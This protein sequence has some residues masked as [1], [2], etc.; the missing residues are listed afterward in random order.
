MSVD[1]KPIQLHGWHRPG[2]RGQGFAVLLCV[3]ALAGCRAKANAAGGADMELTIPSFHQGQIPVEHTCDGADRSPQMTWTAPPAGTKSMTL[4]V[5]DPDA[6]AGT[7]VH[8]VLFDM[9]A[10]RHQLAAGVPA[11]AQLADG[12]R[13]GHNDFGRIG[14][15]GPCPPG[16][17]VH[18]YFFDLYALDAM[19]GLEPGATRAQVETAMRG[20]ILAHA[21]VIGRYGR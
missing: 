12:G 1:L 13:Q 14:Y 5:T 17:S 15:G 20:H 18:R 21:Q 16:H 3:L 10:D 19:L 4:V 9:P 8:W 11:Q 2:R 7:W 6:P